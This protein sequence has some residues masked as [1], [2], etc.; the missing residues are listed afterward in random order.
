M[1]NEI[2]RGVKTVGELRDAIKDLPADMKLDF[3]AGCY[4]DADHYCSEQIKR[5]NGDI[6]DGV[7]LYIRARQY[8]AHFPKTRF[9]YWIERSLKCALVDYLE[10]RV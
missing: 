3:S 4:R 7:E 5:W 2:C 8:E 6:G 1:E 10:N 9:M